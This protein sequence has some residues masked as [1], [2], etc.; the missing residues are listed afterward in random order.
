[1]NNLVVTSWAGNAQANA[2][3]SESIIS[4][5]VEKLKPS[6]WTLSDPKDIAF[7][8]LLVEIRAIDGIQRVTQNNNTVNGNEE[9]LII[10]TRDSSVYDDISRL[11]V[12]YEIKQ[13]RC[14]S[15][16]YRRSIDVEK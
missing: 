12:Q 3:S 13:K 4:T 16:I 7:H 15:Y 8:D 6:F 1:M 5:L 10:G 14:I 2:S 9:L 11:I